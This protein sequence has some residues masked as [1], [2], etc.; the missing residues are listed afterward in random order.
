M[1]FAAA[2]G[3]TVGIVMLH[4][5]NRVIGGI[6]A[7]VHQFESHAATRLIKTVLI[8]PYLAPSALLYPA[9]GARRILGGAAN[10]RWF[11]AANMMMLRIA[12]RKFW[13]KQRFDVAY[14]QDPI[15]AKI[16]LEIRSQYPSMRVVL[17]VHFNESTADE[18][19]GRHKVAKDS[20]LY[21][22]MQQRDDL[23]ISQVDK[24]IFVSQYMRERVLG[25]IPAA[26]LIDSEVIH[27]SAEIHERA[28]S[29]MT[30]DLINIGTLEPRKNHQFL[31]KVLAAARE[32]GR[33]YLLTIVG[34]GE[35]ASDLKEQANR[36]G[37]SGQ[38]EF[39]G[40]IPDAG[41]MIKCHRAYVHSANLEN[42]PIAIIEGLAAR[43]PI[44]AAP[45]GGIP[46][47][48]RD[49]LEGRFWNLDDPVSA[50]KILSD[51]LD[52]TEAYRSMCDAA[53]LR[54]ETTFSP[55]VTQEPLLR[56]VLGRV[57]GFN[58]Y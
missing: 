9:F 29:P 23:T 8:T 16:A 51:V 11:E 49:G 56:A 57:G 43:R 38:V 44:L 58:Q 3:T 46:E 55:M 19:V 33:E 5:P 45:V 50:A 13:R 10:A 52:D 34:T 37:L 15:S 22:K 53:G 6:Q 12:M 17:A 21:V 36:L 25:R 30:R 42:M 18:W 1:N 24:L 40:A 47:V 35:L 48:F 27:N 32:L 54:Y 7:H 26:R 4:R 28:D 39:L 2:E 20:R 41:Q 31:L 14:C